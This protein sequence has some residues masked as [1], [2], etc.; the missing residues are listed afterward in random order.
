MQKQQQRPG[1]LLFVVFGQIEQIVQLDRDEDFFF[2]RLPLLSAGRR[3]FVGGMNGI[4]QCCEY[5]GNK[6]RKWMPVALLHGRISW[7]DWC[8]LGDHTVRSDDWKQ[9]SFV[10]R[11]TAIS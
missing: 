8:R 10:W 1:R 5:D 9:R 6:K 4:A 11:G 7:C 3:C 2:E